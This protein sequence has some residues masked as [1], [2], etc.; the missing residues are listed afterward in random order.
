MAESSSRTSTSGDRRKRISLRQF[1]T[2]LVARLAEQAAAP[3]VVSQLGIETA[4]QRWLCRLDEIEEIL[5]PQ[6]LTPVPL[7]RPWFLGLTNVRGS[8]YSVVDFAFFY[9]KQPTPMDSET[10]LMLLNRSTGAENMALL[11]QQVYGLRSIQ[12]F[13]STGQKLEDPSWNIENWMDADGNVWKE[14]SLSE[15]AKSPAFQHIGR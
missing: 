14:M 9:T 15:L 7:T 8:L 10:R 1:Q 3:D 6:A 12:G 13:A 2:E 4:G 5:T 11:I